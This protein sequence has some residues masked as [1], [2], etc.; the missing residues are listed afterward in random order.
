M[1]IDAKCSSCSHAMWDTK[2]GEY[3]CNKKQRT[4]NDSELAMGCDQF[5]KIGTKPSDPKPEIV[6][7]SGATFTP[8]VSDDAVLSWTNDK[9]LP[10]P[11]PVNIKGKDGKTPTKGV[12]Y[13]TETDKGEMV[14]EVSKS[15][16]YEIWKFTLTD[17]TI[18]E[19]KVALI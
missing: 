13:F 14:N 3:K 5:E 8:H 10:N 11:N 7:R 9:G 6:V 1:S 12:D 15:L 18:V 16:P 4:C 2:W 19:K 17:G